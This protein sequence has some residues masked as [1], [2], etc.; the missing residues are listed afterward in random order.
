M[1]LRSLCLKGQVSIL[2]KGY[3]AVDSRY[4]YFF[5][6]GVHQVHPGDQDQDQ[7]AFFKGFHFLWFMILQCIWTINR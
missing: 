7:G 2:V 5:L 4:F 6:L 1:D 3:P